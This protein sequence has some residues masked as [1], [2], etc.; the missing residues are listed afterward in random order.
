MGVGGVGL[1]R[2]ESGAEVPGTE[3]EVGGEGEQGRSI[4]GTSQHAKRD[5]VRLV[6]EDLVVPKPKSRMKKA[7]SVSGECIRT[8]PVDMLVDGER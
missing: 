5:A 3:A 4:E 7:H 2:T 6:E 1:R 8:W